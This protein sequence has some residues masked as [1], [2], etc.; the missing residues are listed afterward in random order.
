MTAL[1]FLVLAAALPPDASQVRLDRNQWVVASGGLEGEVAADETLWW[2][3]PGCAPQKL[4]A[5]EPASCGEIAK[6]EVNV[7]D[8]KGRPVEKA[9]VLWATD[10]ML[11]ELPD[12]RL[13][14]VV[15]AENG[16][17]LAAVPKRSPVWVRVAGPRYATSWRR[18]E[19]DA[20]IARLNGLPAAVARFRLRGDDG[21]RPVHARIALLPP[22]CEMLCEERLL[23]LDDAT[24]PPAVVA[25]EEMTYQV[26]VWSDSHAPLHRTMTIGSGQEIALTLAQ[27]ATVTAKIVDGGQ[28][29]IPDAELEVRYRLP[30]LRTIMPR[31]AT[32]LPVGG[33]VTMAGLPAAPVEWIASADGYGRR[34]GNT[35][36]SQGKADLGNIVLT[37]ARTARITVLDPSKRPVTN[38]TVVARESAIA[39]TDTH[40]IAVFDQLPVQDVELNVQAKGFLRANA[41]LSR[42]LR[43]LTVSLQQGAGVRAALLME[44]GGPSPA[45]VEVRISNNGSESRAT[46]PVDDHLLLTG[47]RGGTLRLRIAAEGART[48]DTGMLTIADGDVLDLGILVLKSGLV[49]RGTILGE[50]ARPVE[51][52]HI[53]ILHNDGDAPALAYLLEDW[54]EV[55]SA[56]DGTFRVSALSPGSQL[57]IVEASGF[58]RRVIPNVSL[59]ADSGEVDL[60][61]VELARGRTVHLTCRPS[62][63]CGSEASLLLAGSE[64][65]QLA[66]RAPLEEGHATIDAVPPGEVLLRLT[67]LKEIVHESRIDVHRGREPETIEIALPA[68]RVRGE[69]M[70]GAHRARGGS[71]IFE[72]AVDRTSVPILLK[73]ETLQ[74]SNV[75]RDWI[76]SFGASTGCEVGSQGQ[77]MIEELEPGE[78]TVT[79]RNGGASTS[80]ARVSVP[81]VPDHQVQ[82]RFDAHEIAGTVLDSD[83]TPSPAHVEIVDASG[84]VHTTTSGMDGHF[85]LLGIS[86]GSAKVKASAKGRKAVIEVDPSRLDAQNVV[87]QLSAASGGVSVGL[88]EDGRPASGALVFVIG[89][90]GV[91]VAST[92]RDGRALFPGIEDERGVYPVAAYRVGGSWVFGTAGG[93]APARLAL[94]GARAGTLLAQSSGPSGPVRMLTPSGFP[95]DRVL[96]MIGI[97]PQLRNGDSFHLSGLP[98]GTYSISVGMI[99]KSASVTAGETAVSKFE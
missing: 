97:M 55:V 75:G 51:G 89:P 5:G 61:S 14:R 46:V 86:A 3:S 24:Q 33:S 64:L 79:F 96:P 71:L 94:A 91:L 73:T 98:A 18:I 19:A 62:R 70:V 43:Q 41:S 77:F 84:A 82:L 9:N 67:R 56:E 35:P 63:R 16:M 15:T 4:A 52:A 60:G 25:V 1:L 48:Y 34:V 90:R 49:L 69:V 66:I 29:P 30:S 88:E 93:G 20:K 11:H 45:E 95:L 21:S 53:R 28:K 10:E 65:P 99:Q 58:A 92:D 22:R 17:A 12:S 74:G 6:L 78:Y 85:Q 37:A 40:G 31:K 32:T 2:W 38:A 8:P 26:I 59:E 36:L 80:P 76:G 83:G 81:D 23:V 68:V 72:R 50:D 57:L 42:D 44:S 7:I 87:L 39:K 47:L 54:E 27:G 13:P